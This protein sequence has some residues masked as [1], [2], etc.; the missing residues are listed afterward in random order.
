VIA[1]GYARTRP[2]E[3][4]A[5]VHAELTAS[6]CAAVYCDE[7]ISIRA[8]WPQLDRALAAVPTGGALIVCRLIHI[9]RSLEHL[10]D[11]L[12]GLDRRG[13]RFRALHEQLDT[14][15]HGEQPR[16]ITHGLIDARQFWRSEAT[17]DGLAVAVA[18]GRKLG[19]RPA[20]LLTPE[21]DE[22][23]RQ[24][25]ATGRSVTEIADLIGVSR[26]KLYRAMPP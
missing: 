24:L 22:L 6:G 14:A 19:R 11:L 3:D 16:Q 2:G 8:D 17:R 18:A 10:A 4:T 5:P 25:Q 26:A 20:P 15:E 1:I 7:Q 13:V 21:Q 23:A 9:G 12:A